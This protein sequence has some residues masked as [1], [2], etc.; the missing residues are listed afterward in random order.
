MVANLLASSYP[1]RPQ[2]VEQLCVADTE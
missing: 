2:G 1:K